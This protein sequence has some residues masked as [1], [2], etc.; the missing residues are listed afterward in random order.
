MASKAAAAPAMKP[1]DRPAIDMS[2]TKSAFVGNIGRV[3][4]LL[5]P[6]KGKAAD[7]A[8]KDLYATNS[9]VIPMFCR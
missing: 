8:E 7:I 1:I 4:D 3:R 6:A 2:L 5:E 9:F